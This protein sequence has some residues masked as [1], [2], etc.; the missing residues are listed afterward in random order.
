MAEH[1]FVL[2]MELQVWV[3]PWGGE[4]GMGCGFNCDF[5]Q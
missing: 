4:I 2:E 1:G 3:L 5:W